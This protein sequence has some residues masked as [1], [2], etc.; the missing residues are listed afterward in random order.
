MPSGLRFPLPGARSSL[1]ALVVLVAAAGT[2]A[3]LDAQGDLIQDAA[4][5]MGASNLQSI[6]Y[7][8]SGSSF[9]VGQAPG[10]AAPWPRFELTK[11]VALVNYMPPLMREDTVRR[12]VD[13]PPRGGGAGPFNPKTGQGGM[14]PIPGDV[15]Q[16]IVR[17][18]RTDAGLLQITATR[19]ENVL[20]LSVID[21]GAGIDP[22]A[23]VPPGH[24][25]DNTR[26]RLRALYGERASLEITRRPEGGTI[27]T[28]KLPYRELR[29]EPN[30]ETS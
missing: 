19:S 24:G 3:S 18:G 12:D 1:A 7:S 23:P 8:G 5:A 4:R 9:T 26:E 21:D 11:Y 17:N 29:P 10:P 28:L 16:S 6:Q 30:G 20:E 13:F 27:A 22:A 2:W 14:R 15:V 25:I